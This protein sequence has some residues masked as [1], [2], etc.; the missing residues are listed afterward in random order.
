MK[1]VFCLLITFGLVLEVQAE[2]L[3][4]LQTCNDLNS[5]NLSTQMA[6]EIDSRISGV[7]ASDSTK[8]L[9][10][11][12]GNGSGGW[13][14]SSTVWTIKE[15]AVSL[16]FTGA[17]PWSV[18][19]G[20]GASGGYVGAG[21]LISPRHM[22]LARHAGLD[23][24]STVV[25]VDN[26]NN[27]VT[28]TIIGQ[29]TVGPI[30]PLL[31]AE[32]DIQVLLLNEDITEEDGITYYPIIDFDTFKEYVQ[33][34][35]SVPVIMLHSELPVEPNTLREDKVIIKNMTGTPSTTVGYTTPSSPRSDF[36][37]TLVG[38]D[39]GNP[40]FA[41]IGGRLVLVSTVFSASN[42]PFHT[43][44]VSEINSAMTSLGGG[45]QVADLDL[46]CF[47]PQPYPV[48]TSDTFNFDLSNTS[49]TGSEVGT[50]TTSG[51]E[52]VTY[53]ITAG[54][55]D[56]FDIG[57][58]TGII[59][60]ADEDLLAQQ[61]VPS[62]KSVS[63]KAEKTSNTW[64]WP[65]FSTA[66]V[67]VD[68]VELNIAPEFSSDTYNL[69]IAETATAG[70]S[71]GTVSATDQNSV[72]SIS[73]SITAGNTGNIFEISSTTGAI[74][75]A[76]G[77]T[78]DYDVTPS[79]TLTVQALDNGS[80]PLSDTATVNISVTTSG[81]PNLYFS[82]SSTSVP[83]NSGSIN[84]PILVSGT[85]AKD[86][87]I[88]I[89]NSDGTAIEN[90]DYTISSSSASISAGSSFV[91]FSV[92][93]VN[94]SG[95]QSSRSFT[96]TLSSASKA[97]IT[98]PSTYTVTI[99]NVSSSSGGGGG[100]GSSGG[101]SSSSANTNT[102]LNNTNTLVVQNNLLN[103]LVPNVN[104]PGCLV[105]YNFSPL[106]G[107]PCTSSVLVSNSINNLNALS[108]SVNINNTNTLQN[109][110]LVNLKVNT[111]TTLRTGAKDIS[112][113]QLQQ[114]LN[115]KGYTVSTSG[116][117]SLGNETTYF[118]PATRNALIRF[119]KD[120]GLTSDGIFGPKSREKL[121]SI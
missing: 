14:R 37:E 63:V 85:Y 60:V 66:T 87:S 111:S 11:A 44:F 114:L 68:L 71:V 113:R 98:S 2:T 119:Q 121:N 17:S 83:E 106:T 55:T 16:D 65:L 69:S 93:I 62:T 49:S 12:T 41:V 94:R 54:N 15:G 61:S 70:A 53:T 80:S 8:K 32:H 78:L 107:Q 13:T 48:F 112:V 50:V 29:K 103:P 101:G 42:G 21:T 3:P 100:G 95:D 57:S 99:T 91:N 74:T 97:T 19:A 34:V 31:I 58:S 6:Y 4:I 73:Y 116:A 110:N 77:V 33:T 38:G 75:L 39:S 79:Y 1:I 30:D 36:N 25:F 76:S 117:G 90:T 5:T 72:D 20:G 89:S 52:G 104:P 81:R 9:F 120:N 18:Q 23:D 82:G 51:A 108:P 26:S 47:T 84:V 96:L 28:R 92:G 86:V 105:G 7:T 27:I 64:Q 115:L 56:L 46:S 88:N 67:N 45:Y 24:D 118:G 102:T 10:S 59:T 22:V 43:N 40:I 109:N 35:S